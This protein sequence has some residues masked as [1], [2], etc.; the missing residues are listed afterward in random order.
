MPSRRRSDQSPKRPPAVPS[1]SPSAPLSPEAAY[2]ALEQALAVSRTLRRP[3]TVLLVEIADPAAAPRLTDLARFL[4]ETLRDSDGIWPIRHDRIVTLLA[5]ADA[6]G[7]VSP[8]ERIRG[9]LGPEVSGAL[10]LGQITV[11]PGARADDVLSLAEGARMP[12]IS[13]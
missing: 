1:A 5:D 8:I 13:R 10:V 12:L 3:L 11:P 4:G 7:S 2:E 6:R 9:R